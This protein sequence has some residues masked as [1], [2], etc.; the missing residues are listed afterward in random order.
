MFDG[1]GTFKM[2]VMWKAAQCHCV[3]L[4]C[5]RQWTTKAAFGMNAEFAVVMAL[6]TAIVL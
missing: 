6:P 4:Q 1:A 5:G 3:Q 2:L